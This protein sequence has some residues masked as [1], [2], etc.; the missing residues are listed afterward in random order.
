MVSPRYPT[1]AVLLIQQCTAFCRPG[2][3]LC[4]LT[5]IYTNIP[6]ANSHQ[7]FSPIHPKK[8]L[9]RC[10]NKILT[11]SP[12]SGFSI[13]SIKFKKMHFSPLL[14][15]ARYV[16]FSLILVF[17]ICVCHDIRKFLPLFYTKITKYFTYISLV[18]IIINR[19]IPII[20]R[21]YWYLATGVKELRKA[22]GVPRRPWLFVPFF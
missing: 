14:S 22:A 16:Y 12:V 7:Y 9:V 18:E 5:N 3:C 8:F 13:K 6:V 1:W 2:S 19:N 17:V 11:I 10:E 20:W 4:A 15:A 21:K